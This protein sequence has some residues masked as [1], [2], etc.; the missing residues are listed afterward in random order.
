MIL[1]NMKLLK[2][3]ISYAIIAKA[4]SKMHLLHGF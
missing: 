3:Y 4:V 1:M 2:I